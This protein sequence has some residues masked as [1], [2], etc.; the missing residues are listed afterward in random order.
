MRCEDPGIHWWSEL[1]RWEQPSNDSVCRARVFT[2]FF[3][4]RNSIWEEETCFQKLCICHCRYITAVFDSL[5]FHLFWVRKG[6]RRSRLY[7]YTSALL[8]FFPVHNTNSIFFQEKLIFF[9]VFKIEFS[10]GFRSG[11]LTGHAIDFLSISSCFAR[12]QD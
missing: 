8:S 9:F 11:L 12:W 1:I 7:L 6:T 5:L 3:G 2:G 4:Y 10:I